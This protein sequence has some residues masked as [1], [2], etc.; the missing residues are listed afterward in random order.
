MLAPGRVTVAGLG[1]S[2]RRH[3]KSQNGEALAFTAAPYYVT[4]DRRTINPDEIV[5]DEKNP[6][7]Y[8][9]EH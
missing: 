5:A 1:R 4:G 6:A 7:C 9:N 3:G 8:Y 2:L